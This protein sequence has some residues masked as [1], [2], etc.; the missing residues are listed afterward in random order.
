MAWRHAF[1]EEFSFST[2]ITT[3]TGTTTLVAAPGAGRRIRVQALTLTLT[4]VAAQAIDIE[5]TSGTVEILKI[6]ASAP[7]GVYPSDPGPLGVAL[8]ANEALKYVATAGVGCTISGFGW[9]Q[10]S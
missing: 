4:T 9:I 1:A 5:D 7:V 2:P 6:P 3:G 10:E 8:T